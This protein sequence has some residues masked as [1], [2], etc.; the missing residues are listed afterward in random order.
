MRIYG[1]SPLIA[2]PG[3]I[4]ILQAEESVPIAHPGSSVIG[5]QCQDVFIVLQGPSAIIQSIVEL[6]QHPR[7]PGHSCG[8]ISRSSLIEWHG[9][10]WGVN[11]QECLPFAEK[12]SYVIRIPGK[13]AFISHQCSGKIVLCRQYISL[14]LQ[15]HGILRLQPED[16]FI[17]LQ[18]HIHLALQTLC[19]SFSIESGNVFRGD[20]QSRVKA[21]YCRRIIL[22][23]QE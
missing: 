8:S 17:A 22:Q 5:I 3:T 9:E 1:K 21:V 11:S 6:L 2:L 12:S 19:L 18:C 23:C 14:A 4:W 7:V 15:S 16:L 10:F 13:D 20:I